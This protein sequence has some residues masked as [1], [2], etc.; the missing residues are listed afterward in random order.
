MNSKPKTKNATHPLPK[1]GK[2]SPRPFRLPPEFETFT[3]QQIEE[4]NDLLRNNTYASAQQQIFFSTGIRISINK[5]FRYFQKVELADQLEMADDTTEAV[6]QL[7]SVY[8]GQSTDLTQAG[9]ETI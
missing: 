5:L 9:L 7:L 3:P 2:P 4:I 1:A 8:N 6:A